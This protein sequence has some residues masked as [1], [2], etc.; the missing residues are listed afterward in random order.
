M[1]GM[2]VEEDLEQR[3][4]VVALVR[5]R[6]FGMARVRARARRVE[7]RGEGLERRVEK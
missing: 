6:V 4:Y 1:V 2:D 3:L 7:C 5:G